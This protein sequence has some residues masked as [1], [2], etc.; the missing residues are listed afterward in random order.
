VP[1]GQTQFP[2]ETGNCPIGEGKGRANG[3]P[4]SNCLG[5][6]LW[7]MPLRF[8]RM[9][10]GAICGIEAGRS[11]MLPQN[12]PAGLLGRGAPISDRRPVVRGHRSVRRRKPDR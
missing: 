4:L 8:N 6:C 11:P 12:A 5:E 7:A 3:E 10:A 9:T 2:A 1:Q